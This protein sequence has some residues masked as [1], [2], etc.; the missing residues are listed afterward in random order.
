MNRWRAAA[1][2][3]LLLAGASLTAAA[4]TYQVLVQG[5]P[6]G[7]LT[8][9]TGADAGQVQVTFSYRDNGRGPDLDERFTV[10][11]DGGSSQFRIEGRSTYGAE[12]REQFDVV[13]GRARWAMPGDSGDEALQPGALFLPVTYTSAYQ[14]QLVRALLQRP[15]QTAAVYGG[16]RMTVE[17]VAGHTL[18]D[19][20]GVSLFAI[21]GIDTA[22]HLLWLRDD[23]RRSLFASVDPGW[24]LVAQGHE[25]EAEPLLQRQLQAQGERLRTLRQRLAQPLDGST[26]IQGVRWVDTAAGRA[27]GPSDVW[28]FDGRISA[29]VAPG[30][31]GDQADQVIDG[32]GRTL[33]P[34]LIDMHVH[35]GAEDALLH[36]AAGVTTVRD[37][38]NDNAEL[39]VLSR[40][41][42]AGE[43]A[44]P[45]IVAAGFI[46]GQSPFASRGGVVID[47]VDEGRRAIDT[48]A[49]RGYRQIKLYNSIKPAWVR[50]LAAH[51][52][53]RGLRVAG[54]VPA[55]MRAEEAVRAGYDELTHI[56]QLMLNFVVR[57]GDD[58]RTLARFNRVGDDGL[59][60]DLASPQAR[61]FLALL[62]RHKTAV[63]PTVATFEAMFTQRQGQV[64]PGLAVVADHLPAAWKR[65]LKQA[66]VDLD[67]RKARRWAQSYQRLLDLTA[68]L[69]RAG[70][71]LVAGTDDT[72]GFTLHR[73]LELYVR[74]G[75]TP[76][77]AL[78]AA[79]INAARVAGIGERAGSLAA[80]R[81][82]DLLLVDGDPARDISAVRRGVLVVQGRQA[83]APSAL[84]QAQG[85]RP[86]VPAAEIRRSAR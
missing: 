4:Q 20:S 26:L 80:G 38:G 77:A 66:D 43:I 3:W 62:R 58:T 16:F 52:H 40:R 79:T 13:D 18:T 82:A 55:F 7:S 67:G 45:H 33:L 44:G 31:L 63:D 73:E 37:M 54:H 12:V 86:F 14:A 78:Q 35:I 19:G 47:S 74:A 69:H 57:A 32:R 48:Y 46:E 49:A 75:L 5:V 34:G 59:A 65:G 11:A 1:A 27:R 9:A 22:P 25:H 41:L 70:V 10:D 28:L 60:L 83:Y 76:L 21:S 2:A 8:V 72:P 30:S 81:P 56:N 42:V 39:Q 71:P 51:A 84:Y 68:A 23:D 36:L 17:R 53:R 64:H 85:I 61:R 50:P 6:A 24:A 15:A 29:I